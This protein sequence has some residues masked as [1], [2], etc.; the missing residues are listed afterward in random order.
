[1]SV[2]G[3]DFRR[4]YRQFWWQRGLCAL[5]ILVAAACAPEATPF[6]ADMP[7]EPPATPLPTVP[8]PIRYALHPN[9]EG[10]VADIGAIRASAQVE[11]LA[12]AINFD[13]LGTR[14]DVIAAYGDWSGWTR[15]PVLPHVALVVNAHAT[16]LDAPLLAEVVRQS[17]DPESILAALNIPGA[18]ADVAQTA[19]PQLLRTEL[20]NQGFPDGFLVTLAYAYTPGVFQLQGQLR[21]AGVDSQA[22]LLTNPE[23]QAAFG[24]G[25]LHLG[26]VMWT[27][28]DERA[29]WVA[30]VGEANVIDLY[31]LPI[32]YRA[33]SELTIAVTADGW[34]IA[35]W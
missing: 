13:D 5:L 34:P 21:A 9:T 23:I 10:F 32:S 24:E 14:Y 2:P 22:L 31:T 4:K 1:M 20:A 11:Q 12:E 18:I 30:Q 8:P 6:P 17:A 26:M 33:L 27:T 19:A 15:S 16:P 29:G 28:A 7:T 35:A 25:W 3:C